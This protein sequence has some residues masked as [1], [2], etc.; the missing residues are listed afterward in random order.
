[1][2]TACKGKCARYVVKS[3]DGGGGPGR[4][5][6]RSYGKGYCR[7]TVCDVYLKWDGLW[8][9]CCGTR[10]RNRNHSSRVRRARVDRAPRVDEAPAAG[11]A[12]AAVVG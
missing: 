2:S 9:P 1:M 4:G 11:I 10:V 8:C 5:T 12:V 3:M 7:C 6:T